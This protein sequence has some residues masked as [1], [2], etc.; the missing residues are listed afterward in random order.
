[1]LLVIEVGNTNT[2]IGV[3]DGA[4]LLVSWRLTT[5]ARADRRRVRRCSS[6]RCSARAGIEPP[7]VTGVAIS[8]VVPPVQQ[9]LEWMCEKYF[10]GEPVHRA[11]RASTSPM[12]LNVDNP[13]EVGADRVVQGGGRV[14]LYGAA[15]HRGR[16]RHRDDLRLR[17]RARRVRRRGDRAR[18]RRRAADALVS[19][20]RPGSSASS[21]SGPRTPSAATPSPTS[22]RASCTAGPGSSTGSSSACRPSWTATPRVIATGG[23][24][25]ADARG[26]PD[27]SRRSTSTWPS[28]ACA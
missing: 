10:G 6:R 7:H 4:R 9:A 26:V 8:N 13:R 11:S 22:S 19:T 5:P 3:Y 14:A 17:Q 1:M 20:A 16:L 18:H 21:S 2:K 15:A 24:A 28:R 23:H 12:P 27:P 25:G